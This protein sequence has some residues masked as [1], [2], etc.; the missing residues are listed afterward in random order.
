MASPEFGSAKVV[1]ASEGLYEIRVG[2][3]GG[4]GC[5][6]GRVGE[7]SCT[8][9]E[10]PTEMLEL[11]NASCPASVEAQHCRGWEV[12]FVDGEWARAEGVRLEEVGGAVR[13]TVRG[14]TAPRAVRYAWSNW[15]ML[16][17]FGKSSGL[18]ALP[19]HAPL[20]LGAGAGGEG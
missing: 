11:R 3:R 16:T 2:L 13:L 15:P 17:A 12:D 19:F 5:G 18:P 4:G 20:E 1:G 8:E 6:E 14:D 10:R 9:G 7:E